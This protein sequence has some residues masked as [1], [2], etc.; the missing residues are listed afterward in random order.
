MGLQDIVDP[1][2]FQHPAQAAYVSY[3]G[4]D[5]VVVTVH[6]SWT[7]EDLRK[8][9]KQLLQGDPDVIVAGDFKTTEDGIEYLAQAIGLL[10]MAPPG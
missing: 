4:F 7:D 2:G 6:L 8:A 1:V 5:A 3:R 9:E 10:V